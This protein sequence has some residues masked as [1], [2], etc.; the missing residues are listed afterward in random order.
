MQ[1]TSQHLRL[2]YKFSRQFHL[3]QKKCFHFNISFSSQILY[4]EL[5]FM[6]FIE[7]LF[8]L[9]TVESFL[10]YNE[11]IFLEWNVF[12][13]SFIF[14]CLFTFYSLPF[15]VFSFLLNWKSLFNTD[16]VSLTKKEHRAEYIDSSAEL[17]VNFYEKPF[18]LLFN[19]FIIIILTVY[20]IFVY[21]G[22]SAERK[23]LS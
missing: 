2:Y 4:F 18:Y 5:L 7:K 13:Q 19:S 11:F 1:N 12:Y 3:V 15:F 6:I 22:S 14:D 8:N 16:W 10:W 21:R 17:Q 9:Y 20:L 23:H